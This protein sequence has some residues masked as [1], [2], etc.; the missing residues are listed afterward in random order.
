MV[1]RFLSVIVFLSALAVLP[2]CSDGVS[3]GNEYPY[4]GTD[5][6]WTNS[7]EARH[8]FVKREGMDYLHEITMSGDGILDDTQS[9]AQAQLLAQT[10]WN[11]SRENGQLNGCSEHTLW[12]LPRSLRLE[13]KLIS[14]PGPTVI[15]SSV[16][17]LDAANLIIGSR[18]DGLFHY[19]VTRGEWYTI[20]FPGRGEIT[21]LCKDS[22]QGNVLT[23]V[24]TATDGVYCK[25]RND[26]LWLKLP[27]PPGAVSSLEIS[28]SD[29]LFAVI[30]NRLWFAQRPFDAWAE[31][32]LNPVSG[33]INDIAILETADQ[34]ILI[35]ATEAM[36]IATIQLVQSM[37]AQIAYSEGFGFENV[38]Q[39]SAV[40]S[41]PYPAVGISNLP[42]LLVEPQPDV[43][44]GIPVTTS[45]LLTCVSQSHTSGTILI[46]SAT[47]IYRFYG[48]KPVIAGLQ[49][50]SIR[51]LQGSPDGAFFAGTEEGFYRSNDDG[52]TW[53][54]IDGGSVMIRVTTP[55]QILPHG[56]AVGTTW[57]AASLS[58]A[59]QTSVTLAGRVIHHFDEIFLPDNR[60]RYED[61]MMVRYAEETP[62]GDVKA[63]SYV[64]TAYFV[65]GK[66]LVYLEET[67]G[68]QVVAQSFLKTP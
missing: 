6:L 41:A 16:L 30:N 42:M 61:V 1:I 53:T 40:A 54:R 49:G 21:A 15:S 57:N 13:E 24:G 48:S 63:G 68:G 66:G 19:N 51:T 67:S 62:A 55:W 20:T 33:N 26:S 46:G 32:R 9:N 37:P 11:Y 17:C 38:I 65:R 59:N 45:S 10:R 5:Y 56:F 43:W 39:L 2:A 36:G 34:E 22:T 12:H 3:P 58:R 14:A 31:F 7:S 29:N 28:G 23:F 44:I 64:W 27:T 60:G 47:G 18:A 4:T 35:V 50:R 25:P 8:F 52:L